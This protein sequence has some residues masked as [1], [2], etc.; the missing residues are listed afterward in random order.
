MSSC[1][2]RLRS[3][4]AAKEV[5]IADAGEVGS[6]GWVATTPAS[7]E[8]WARGLGAEA[9]I[10]MESTA[11]ALAIAGILGPHVGRVVLAD[12]KAVRAAARG[13]AKTDRIGRRP[14]G[15]APGEWLLGRGVGARRG[16]PGAPAPRLAGCSSC[17]SAP[18]RRTRSTP[19]SAGACSGGRR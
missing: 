18:A 19:C 11:N 6:G 7:L 12:P 17:T 5:G 1:P 4:L 14:A 2:P 15:P 10:A 16:D 9:A 3:S 8:H 13:G